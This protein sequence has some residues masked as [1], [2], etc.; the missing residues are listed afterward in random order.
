LAHSAYY[1]DVEADKLLKASQHRSGLEYEITGRI[2]IRRKFQT[3]HIP[4]VDKRAS[5]VD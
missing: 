3:Y 1:N 5:P 4:Q 2:G